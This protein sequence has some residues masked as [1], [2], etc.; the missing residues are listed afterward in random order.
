MTNIAP[1]HF[2]VH[3]WDLLVVVFLILDKSHKRL[4]IVGQLPEFMCIFNPFPHVPTVVPVQQAVKF[5]IT[6]KIGMLLG[7]LVGVFLQMNEMGVWILVMGKG[8]V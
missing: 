7:Y 2:K 5:K 3:D 4:S 6:K 8:W 1:I